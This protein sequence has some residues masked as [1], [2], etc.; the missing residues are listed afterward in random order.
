MPRRPD[1]HGAVDHVLAGHRHETPA[2][3]FEHRLNRGARPSAAMPTLVAAEGGS[4]LIDLVGE[5][6]DFLMS[7]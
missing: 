5:A 1:P 4:T 7:D 3:A 6:L 2:P